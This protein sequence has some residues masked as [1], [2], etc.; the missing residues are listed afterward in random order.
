MELFQKTPIF[1]TP[2]TLTK[3]EF[4]LAEQWPITKI[5]LVK[6]L[7][8]SLVLYRSEIRTGKTAAFFHWVAPEGGWSNDFAFGMR[9][10]GDAYWVKDSMPAHILA[11]HRA[12]LAPDILS[13][14]QGA[15]MKGYVRQGFESPWLVL[16]Y[17]DGKTFKATDISYP[18]LEFVEVADR[19]GFV[20]VVGP[21]VIAPRQDNGPH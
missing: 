10:I 1:G 11:R 21:P 20:A 12:P 3:E 13:A 19:E 9:E 5:F 14:S 18:L 4:A 2:V 6:D 16:N 17:V 7:R 15:V 8:T